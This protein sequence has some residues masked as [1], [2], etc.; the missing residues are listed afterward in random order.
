M[1]SSLLHPP[2]P[3]PAAKTDSVPV[4]V[5]V[6]HPL[7]SVAETLSKDTYQHHH[8]N[9]NNSSSLP[10]ISLLSLPTEIH[11]AIAKHLIYPDALSLKHT[12]SRFYYLV[13]TGVA[14]KVEW[15]VERRSL[16]LDCPNDKRCDLGSDLRF[17]RG[18]VP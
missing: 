6:D 15:L 8:H 13:D 17:C 3:A 2:R 5:Q 9:D 1:P 14:L 11:L 16:H 7:S 12:S 4:R 10:R 18:S